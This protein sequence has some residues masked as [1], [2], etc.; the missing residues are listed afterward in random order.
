[1]S[2]ISKILEKIVAAK[3]LEHL[4]TN[5]LL[6]EHQ[7]GFTPGKSTEHN[8]IQITNYITA[9]LND[10]D[11]CIGVFIDLKKAFDV[12]SHPILLKKLS[13]IGVS[14]T[15]LKWFKTNLSNRTQCVDINNTISN[16]KNLLLSVIQGSI[17]GPILFLI[18]INDL[19]RC[20]TL[21]TTLFADDGTCLARNENLAT[22]TTYVNTELN[23][24]ANWFI[25]NKMCVNTSKTKFIIFHNPTKQIDNELAKLF[26]N[27]NIIGTPD[28]PSKYFEIERIHN[29]GQTKNFKLLGI[30]LDEHLSFQFH[31]D[32]LCAKI[33]KS[34]YIINRAKNLLPTSCLLTLYYALVHSHLNYCC[35]IYGSATRTRLQKLFLKQKQA[36][37][38][39]SNANYRANT[40]PL[41][42]RHQ[43]LPIFD[44]I[45]LCNLK[46]MHGFYFNTLPF[47]FREMWL[48]NRERNPKNIR[49]RNADDLYIPTHNYVTLKRLPLF[50]LPMLWN[51]EGPHKFTPSTFKFQKLIKS[52]LL[53]NV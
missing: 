28:D 35:T 23:K 41:F 11:Y 52:R 27:S 20:T 1:L 26:F 50:N 17:L 30:L 53:E 19:F 42:R 12:C 2:S 46:F 5:N 13:L 6:Y 51:N 40:S 32:A 39:I 48:T 38:I 29:E 7:Y 37:R 10:N 34:L 15:A 25:A 47:S 21:F 31:I 43:I 33:S 8:L 36:I 22:L 16:V 4:S 44:L 45:T 9:A 24:I 14:N 49:L 18:Y 3:L